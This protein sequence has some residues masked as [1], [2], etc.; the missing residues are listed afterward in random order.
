MKRLLGL[1]YII[2]GTAGVALAGT[3]TPSVPEINPAT[4]LGALTL[5]GSGRTDTAGW[6][7]P[8]DPSAAEEVDLR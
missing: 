7:G 4:A 6:H 1:V 2:A 5:L 3:G 8:G